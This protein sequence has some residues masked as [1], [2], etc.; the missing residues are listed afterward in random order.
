MF[1]QF[2]ALLAFAIP[3]LLM[4]LQIEADETISPLP[5]TRQVLFTG[6][7]RPIQEMSLSSEVNGKCL[8]V[9]ADVGE[10]VP[11]SKIFASVDDT[12]IRLDLVAND[13]SAQKVQ[14][15]LANEKK[16]L[17]R[18]T[19]LW[20][21]NS[22]TLAK[23]DNV[24]LQASLHEIQLQNLANERLRLLENQAR[25]T[26]SA[27]QGWQV[28]QRMIE[29]GEYVQPGQS[30]ATLGDFRHL[31][32][33]MALSFN[34]LQALKE[35]ETL[36]LYLPDV[37]A[38]VPTK[39][40]HISPGF[41]TGTRKIPVDLIVNSVQPNLKKP[42]RSGIRAQIKL[43]VQSEDNTFL[44]PQSAVLNRYDSYWIVKE[45]GRKVKVIFLGTSADGASVIISTPEL[46]TT[47]RLL[48]IT[49]A[50]FP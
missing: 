29:P 6:F 24:R 41:H 27:P 44:L 26:V 4:P 12:F 17:E 48:K 10:T 39:I 13:L 36:S 22:T 16:T 34:E 9:F 32:V 18:Y 49:P 38:T 23:L 1:V 35:T 31:L 50:D 30:L 15:Q 28:M 33:S 3:V 25:H 7:T 46:H 11:Q 43:T 47:D 2:A 20:K 8:K 40:H 42:L 21:K 5:Y 37:D 19:S 14:Q 45:D